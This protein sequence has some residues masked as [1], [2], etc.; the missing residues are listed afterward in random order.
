MFFQRAE[1]HN[2]IDAVHK[3]GRELAP[4]RFDRRAVDLLIDFSIGMLHAFAGSETDSTCDQ[5]GHVARAEVRSQ[6]DHAP[7]K[8]HAAVV[9]E[10]QRRLVQNPKQELPERVR[11]FFDLIKQHQGQL[12]IVAMHAI[13]IFLRQHR[14]GLAV[15]KISRRRTNE[16][17]NLMRVLEFGAVNLHDGVYIGKEHFGGRLNYARL[18]GTGRAKE[19]HRPDWAIRWIHA[20]QKNLVE[21]AHAPDGTL[22]TNNACSQAFFEIL[23]TRALLFRVKE[24]CLINLYFWGFHCFSQFRYHCLISWQQR[25][26]SC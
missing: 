2:L 11:G 26:I 25:F 7:R 8:V 18:A 22:L 14:R 24:D 1:H 9:A 19:Q 3:L 5:F 4:R 12:Q 23:G 20:G 10:C 13:K 21:A 17:G 15:T 16:L 6:D